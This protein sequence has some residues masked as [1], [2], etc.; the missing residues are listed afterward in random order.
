MLKLQNGWIWT[1]QRCGRFWRSSRRPKTPLA[2]Q[3]SK[4][5][6]VSAPPQ[7]LKNKR[8]K[9]R[10]NPRRSCKS[11]TPQSVWANPPCT[12]CW[13]TI[14]EWSLSRCCI[15]RSLRAIMWQWGSKNAG[16]FSRRWP[17]ARCRTSCS[18]TRRNSTSSR[19]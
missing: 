8:E 10:R 11:W 14:W 15:A 5:N 6:G 17:T 1:V 16:K 13:G 19:R 4:E 12:R 3:G 7:L 2:D 9:L 18:R